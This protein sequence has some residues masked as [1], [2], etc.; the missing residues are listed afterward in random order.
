[1]AVR[2][3]LNEISYT[4]LQ[5]SL[6]EEVT[7]V[8]YD[9][10]KAAEKTVF[11]CMKGARADSHQFIP[12]VLEAGCRVL[13]VEHPVEV[14]QDVTVIQVENGRQALAFLSAARFGYPAKKMVTIGVT[15]TKGKTTTTH[16]IKAVLESCGKK[17]GMIGTTGVVIGDQTRPTVN[18]TPESWAL[19]QAF[20]E[21]VKAGCEYM[22]MEV[23]SQGLKMH[24]VDG[25][26]T[27][28]FIKFFIK[29]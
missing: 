17:V 1:M 12:Q 8:I 26:S 20:D 18:T 4:L 24:R 28:L 10:R 11:V 6:E 7:E 5:G 19:H 21:M 15:G 3:W 14:P 23:S 16:M 22:V 27:D 25:I 29:N 2:D 9:S 13:V